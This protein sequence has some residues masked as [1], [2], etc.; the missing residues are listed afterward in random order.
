MFLELWSREAI[1]KKEIT[2]PNLFKVSLV[3]VG[4]KDLLNSVELFT[5]FME[6]KPDE[7]KST[8][9]EEFI[10]FEPCRKSHIVMLQLLV[11]QL[12]IVFGGSLILFLIQA[13]MN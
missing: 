2:E 11:F 12:F 1:G 3:L 8:P 4:C 10:F 5:F 9:A 6:A 13:L 7:R